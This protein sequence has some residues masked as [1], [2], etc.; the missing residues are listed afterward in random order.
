M[1]LRD[2]NRR[3]VILDQKLG[4]GGEAA[5]FTVLRKPDVVAKVY[6]RRTGERAGKL[7]S[8]LAN[9]PSDPTAGKGHVSICWPTALLFDWRKTCAGFLMPRVD[10]ASTVPVFRLYNPRDR[11]RVSPGF[12]WRYLL[13]TAFNLASAVE[14]IH[15]RGCVIGDFNE[16]NVLVTNT[17]LVTLVDCDS[18][19]VPRPGTGTYFRCTVGKPDFTP[20]ELQ[21][22]AFDQIDRTPSHDNFSLG[23]MIFLL[24]MEGVHPFNGVWRESGDAPPL[25]DRIRLGCFP[26]AGSGKILPAPS[27]PP[28]DILPADVRALTLRCFGDGFHDPMSRPSPREWRDCLMQVEKSLIACGANPH[29]VFANHIS[30]CPWCERRDRLGGFDPYPV[31][32]QQVALGP[33]TFVAK[34]GRR[35]GVRWAVLRAVPMALYRMWQ[36]QASAPRLTVQFRRHV[37]AACAA[38][39]GSI[40][41]MWPD[42]AGVPMAV[43]SIA[44]LIVYLGRIGRM[45]GYPV[46]VL[47]CTGT[48][49]VSWFAEWRWHRDLGLLNGGLFAVGITPLMARLLHRHH[50]GRRLLYGLW[51]LTV[52]IFV[53]T[54]AFHRS[55]LQGTAVPTSPPSIDF[56]ADPAS[57]QKGRSATLHWSVRNAGEVVI[58]AVGRVASSGSSEVSPDA[59]TTYFLT[60]T[61][62]GG[63]NKKE[64][65]VNVVPPATTAPDAI[66]KIE[67]LLGKGE[68]CKALQECNRAEG[69]HGPNRRISDL[70]NTAQEAIKIIG[71]TC[72]EQ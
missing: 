64:V 38:L 24:L 29:H 30:H 16:S 37:L 1:I 66:K 47:L 62:P 11:Q 48:T 52:V 69:K 57:I 72:I 50:H 25:G 7:Q 34:A 3:L 32:A 9:A 14:A 20:P 6:H 4:A 65:H 67:S 53:A 43:I 45:W 60:A 54:A 28:F 46:A 18:M 36:E 33:A 21:T 51:G 61:G 55:P 56:A 41:A 44:L 26:Y 59:S 13:R 8:M 31:D 40:G 27:A 23:V 15:A 22:C 10:F 5:V 12:T 35:P 71:S 2:Q 39:F 68:Y 70:R 19:Q 49:L 63:Q 42:S 17:A 58:D